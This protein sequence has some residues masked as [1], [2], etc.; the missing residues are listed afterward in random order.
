MSRVR[1]PLP[2]PQKEMRDRECPGPSSLSTQGCRQVVRQGTLTPSSAGSSP[3]IPA[4]FLPLRW[5]GIEYASLAQLA[6]HLPFKQGVRGSNPRRGTKRGRHLLVSS[7]FAV[8]PSG[9]RS[10]YLLPAESAAGLFSLRRQLQQGLF[11]VRRSVQHGVQQIL[12]RITDLSPPQP[13][14][15]Q[16][17]ALH[18]QVLQ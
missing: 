15:H 11:I 2:T 14:R 9:S 6:E 3:A 13:Q 7:S 8:L 16:V 18:R 12:Q 17:A 5:F 4:R 10:L 1:V